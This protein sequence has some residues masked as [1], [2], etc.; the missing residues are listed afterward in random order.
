MYPHALASISLALSQLVYTFHFSILP[1]LST[2]D[3]SLLYIH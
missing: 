2:I 1:H 3:Q